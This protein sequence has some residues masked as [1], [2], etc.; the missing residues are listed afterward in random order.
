MSAKKPY[1][2][3]C[4]MFLSVSPPHEYPKTYYYTHIYL[5][6]IKAFLLIYVFTI[7]VF[8]CMHRWVEYYNGYKNCTCTI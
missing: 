4:G 1:L 8:K 5:Y 6:H 7:C 2:N 3:Y